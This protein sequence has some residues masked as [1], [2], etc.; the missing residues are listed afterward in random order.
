[1]SK[2]EKLSWKALTPGREPW[3]ARISAGMSGT[4]LMSLPK[5]AEVLVNCVPVSCMPSPESPANLM[6]TRSTSMT[7]GSDGSL[8]SVVNL[9][10]LRFRQGLVRLRGQV[11]QLL[12]ECLGEKMNYIRR[13]QNAGGASVCIHYRD[14]FHAFGDHQLDTAGYCLLVRQGDGDP[15]GEFA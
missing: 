8:V 9:S 14:V 11:Q 6:V 4:V 1:M 5:T 15:G 13:P 12:W 7:S 2:L 10:T 3:G